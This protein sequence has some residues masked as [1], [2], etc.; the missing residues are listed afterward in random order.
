MDVVL[1][2][3]TG[4][5]FRLKPGAKEDYIDLHRNIW[6]EL[7]R[8]LDQSG[9]RNYSIWNEGDLLFAYYEVDDRQYMEHTLNSSAVYEKWRRLMEDYIYIDPATGQKEWFMELVFLNEGI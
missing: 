9:M 7:K 5:Y 1:M 3:R 2:E 8:T 6:P 4:I